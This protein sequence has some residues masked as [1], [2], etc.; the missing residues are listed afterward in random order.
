MRCIF[1]ALRLVWKQLGPCVRRNCP[2]L[3]PQK[4]IIR[5]PWWVATRNCSSFLNEIG[6]TGETEPKPSRP[7]LIL[8]RNKSA[9]FVGARGLKVSSLSDRHAP[10]RHPTKVAISS[11]I[12]RFIN[13]IE[14][15]GL[16]W[17]IAFYIRYNIFN[18]QHTKKTKQSWRYRNCLK[19]P[20][21]L[22]S[23]ACSL[24][25]TSIE[26]KWKSFKHNHHQRFRLITETASK[27]SLGN[28]V[29]RFS[30]SLFKQR[31]S[32]QWEFLLKFLYINAQRLLPLLWYLLLFSSYCF[33]QLASK[34]GR[35]RW[36]QSLREFCRMPSDRNCT[37]VLLGI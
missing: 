22:E 3:L 23:P 4:N 10:S 16:I 18:I 2:D 20:N 24:Q 27:S 15:V 19:M 8:H 17:H 21:R 7:A 12:I 31:K 30:R 5:R 37:Q 29:K 1:F 6:V 33:S 9:G 25:Q 34:H 36:S 14:K 32:F 11:L 28:V 13:C 26:K 35:P